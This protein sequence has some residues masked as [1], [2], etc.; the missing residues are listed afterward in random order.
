M[1]MYKHMEMD[2]A[3]ILP[4][5]FFFFFNNFVQL[6]DTDIYFPKNMSYLRFLSWFRL[7]KSVKSQWWKTQLS[8]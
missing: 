8:V 7:G 6:R 3:D 4:L 2:P 5:A 1:H